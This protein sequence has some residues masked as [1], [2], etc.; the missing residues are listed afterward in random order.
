MCGLPASG[1]N[2][3]VAAER[4][5]LPV[6]SFDDAREQLGL[7]HGKNEGAVAHAAIDNAK[8]FLRAKTPF[9]W[10]ATHLSEQMRAKTLNLLFAYN[11]EVEVVYLERPRAELL[12]RN[13]RRDTSLS[14]KA[15]EGMLVRWE[16]P[17]PTEAH[18]VEYFAA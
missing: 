1:K 10:N 5:G 18:V 16:L 12:R 11:A 3:W 13:S 7:R 2:T 4:A 17:L 6:V 8:A 14:N 15:L 9:V